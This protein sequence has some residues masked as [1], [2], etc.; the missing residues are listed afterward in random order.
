MRLKTASAQKSGIHKK[1]KKERKRL[2]KKEP[3]KAEQSQE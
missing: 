3:S 1:R 2:A